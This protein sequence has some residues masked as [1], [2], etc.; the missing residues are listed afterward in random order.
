VADNRN[1]E[2]PP[3]AIPKPPV[4]SGSPPTGTHSSPLIGPDGKWQLPPGAPPPAIAPFDEKK[5]KEFQTAWANYLGVQV[6]MTNSIGMKLVLIPPGDF[7]M[8]SPKELIEEKLAKNENYLNRLAGEGPQHRVRITEPFY[9]GVYAVTQGE[10]QRVM[11][12]NPSS[13]SATGDGKEEV[14]GMNTSRFP[15]EQVSWGDAMDFCRDLSLLPE[16]KAA[17]RRY[18]VWSAFGGAVGV[19]MPCWEHGPIRFQFG[20]QR[21][22]RRVRGAG[23]VR[24]RVVQGQ[25]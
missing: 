6:G 11:G 20:P 15:V 21:N 12:N 1:V 22:F 14:A 25:F 3:R 17:R 4:V 13:F 2:T 8:G 10:Y 7:L 16:E 24:L 23:A 18:K 19:C 9:L 5:A